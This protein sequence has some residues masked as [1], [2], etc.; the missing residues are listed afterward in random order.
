MKWPSGIH[1]SSTDLDTSILGAGVCLA[2][3]GSRGCS[4]VRAKF[5]ETHFEVRGE[6]FETRGSH[7]PSGGSG[8]GPWGA[9][10]YRRRLQ[11]GGHGLVRLV[12]SPW[13]EAM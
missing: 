12:P 7:L 9:V 1:V 10:P 8:A 13:R 3:R 2:F 11:R 5:G 6:S 4:P